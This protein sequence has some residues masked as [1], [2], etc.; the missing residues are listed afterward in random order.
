MVPAAK[1]DDRPPPTRPPPTRR[2][3]SG[4]RFPAQ[5]ARGI[6]GVESG[7][8]RTR[9]PQ[10]LIS[11]RRGEQSVLHGQL[12][13][14]QAS[15]ESRPVDPFLV[16]GRKGHHRLQPPTRLSIRPVRY[17]YIRI[18]S[19]SAVVSVPFFSQ[20]WFDTPSLPRPCTRPA[21]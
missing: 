20:I 5:F 12:R 8:A 7:A 9:F 19:V 3:V 18:R 13:T 17:G 6:A 14:G 2:Q 11:H 21:R 1:T 10:L 16:L 15:G 4:A